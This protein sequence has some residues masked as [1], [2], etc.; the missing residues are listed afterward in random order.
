VRHL[1][2]LA[3]LAPAIVEGI[4]TGRQS[5]CLSAERLKLRNRRSAAL[6]ECRWGSASAEVLAVQ[7]ILR[8][9]S[10][11]PITRAVE[12]RNTHAKEGPQRYHASRRGHR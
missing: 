4:C 2:P 3:L 7:Q 8:F 9:M 12:K 1:V 6:R 10:V 11:A 5:V